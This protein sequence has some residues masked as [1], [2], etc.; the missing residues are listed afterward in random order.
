MRK[1]YVYQGYVFS[2]PEQL[3]RAKNEANAIIYLRE[4]NDFSDMNNLL[5]LY[6]G[7]LSKNIMTTAVGIDF[8]KE[9][10]EKLVESELYEE[11]EIR[12][13]PVISIGRDVKKDNSMKKSRTKSTYPDLYENRN[14][15]LKAVCL[16][17]AVLVVCLLV[18]ILVGIRS[19]ASVRDEVQLM[20]KYAALAQQLQEK[21]ELLSKYAEQLE[22]EGVLLPGWEEVIGSEEEEKD[23]EDDETSDYIDDT[24]YENETYEW[25]IKVDGT[26]EITGYYGT[27]EDKITIPK[28]LDG[29]TVTG[30]AAEVFSG[31]TEVISISIPDCV[32]SIGE[33]AFAGCSS[34]TSVSLSKNLTEIADYLFAECESLT[35]IVLPDNIARIG[36][37]AFSGCY[38]LATVEL[39][40]KLTSIGEYSFYCCEALKKISLPS[41]LITLGSGAFADCTALEKIEIPESVTSLEAEV[42]SNCSVMTLIIIPKTVQYIEDTAFLGC[43]ELVIKAPKDSVAAEFAEENGVELK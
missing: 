39:P 43:D 35:K 27:E 22:Q 11:E 10:R 31:C 36:A 3:Q 16:L 34:L 5:K 1:K 8:L 13:V 26:A 37:E 20:E 25:M 7:I 12:P 2:N 42:F 19:L 21:E 30:I 14:S 6:N 28:K 4:K 33:G 38:A 17:L 29:K 40:K 15:V 18:I 32:T 24:I 9:I 23:V 41:K